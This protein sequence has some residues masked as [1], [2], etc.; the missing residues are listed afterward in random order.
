MEILRIKTSWD[1]AG[2]AKMLN[3]RF[4]F[5]EILT[6]IDNVKTKNTMCKSKLHKI[7]IQFDKE[8]VLIK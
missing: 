3:L 4:Q 8:K 1:Y 7:I 2:V 5:S 6:V